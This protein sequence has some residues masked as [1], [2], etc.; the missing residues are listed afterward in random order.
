VVPEGYT[1]PRGQHAFTV[2]NAYV[3]DDYFSTMDIP[4]IRGRDF[5]DSDRGDT[6]RVAVVSSF[7]ANHY[8]PRQDAVGKRFHLNNATGPLVEIVGIVKNSKY[9][10]IAEPPMDFIYLP[11]TQN[12]DNGDA[13]I[14]ALTLLTE[15]AAPDASGL[16]SVVRG[17]VRGIDPNMPVHDERTMANYY[18]Q[19]AVKTPNII[20][21]T[22]AIFGLLGLIL[23]TAGLYGLIAYSVS[24]RFREI[25]IRMALGAD[26]QTVVAMVLRQ[27]LTLA[28]I[29][30]TA[31]LILSFLA[32]RVLTSSLWIASFSHLNYALF[33]AIAAP[34]LLVTLLATYGPARRAS[35]I[36]PVRALRE[37]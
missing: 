7:F 11:Y 33:P 4:L 9:L 20:A 21:Q 18:D 28:G 15:S 34:L 29:G 17:V 19:R 3:S 31:G 10:W 8:W 35:L 14:S 12:N 2:F 25:G 1:L 30:V 36:D 27:G 16:A 37:E 5:R 23:A 6:P 26:R 13:P 32:C 24:R 22:V